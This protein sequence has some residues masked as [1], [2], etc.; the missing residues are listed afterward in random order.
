MKFLVLTLCIVAA[1]TSQEW[2][3]L[4]SHEVLQVQTVWKA[5]SHDEVEILYTIFKAHPDIQDQFPQF[6]GHY[7]EDIKKTAPFA[8]HAARIVGFFGEYISLLGRKGNQETIKK[9]LHDLAVFHKKRGISKAQFKKF[10]QT[11]TTYVKSHSRWNADI[12]HSWDDA[13]SKAFLVIYDVLD[14]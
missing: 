12:S 7:L 11:M 9:L 4:D 13:F 6:A 2:L 8:T 3:T 5:V 1:M 14:S 10:R